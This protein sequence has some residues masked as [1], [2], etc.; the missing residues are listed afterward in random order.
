MDDERDPEWSETA[1][2]AGDRGRK[3]CVSSKPNSANTCL[4][5][6]ESVKDDDNLISP[7]DYNS[8]ITILNAAT[9]RQYTAITDL[10]CRLEGNEV[11]D[12]AY[13]RDCRSLFTMKRDLEALSKQS[14]E[15]VRDS[16]SKFRLSSRGL[17][18]KSPMAGPS[19]VYE[20]I[21]IFCDKK[22]KY[23]KN[24]RTKETLIKCSEFRGDDSIRKA[25]LHKKDQRI[26]ALASRELVAAE[27]HYHRS[28]YVIYTRCLSET[29]KVDPPDTESDME[30]E[31]D[32]SYED[33]EN[34]AFK[35]L[36]DWIRLNIFPARSVISM[37]E[38]LEQHICIMNSL[39]VT[40]IKRSTKTHFR[41]KLETEFGD[42][43]SITHDDRG[44]LLVMSS[45][46][47]VYDLAK[48]NQRLSRELNEKKDTNDHTDLVKQVAQILRRYK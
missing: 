31:D 9:I 4:I 13:H 10:A 48:T 18:R 27:A 16:P 19:R 28:C 41:R 17:S 21:C 30:S 43:I 6:H 36:S 26:L 47:T 2:G 44:K 1:G 7:R 14:K 3:P 32:K 22:T 11:P 39:G 42:A 33:V 37:S 46:I 25:A 12:I 34:E 38:L 29:D 35:T 5:H 45:T 40:E 24:S 8:W 15:T 20:A 23:K